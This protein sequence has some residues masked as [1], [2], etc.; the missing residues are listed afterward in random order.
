MSAGTEL[1]ANEV[2]DACLGLDETV[3]A[4]RARQVAIT[5]LSEVSSSLAILGWERSRQAKVAK[6]RQ[7]RADA[8]AKAEQRYAAAIA[9]TERRSK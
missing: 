3:T 7:E 5:A 1:L 8:K 9:R 6:E 4:T 2:A